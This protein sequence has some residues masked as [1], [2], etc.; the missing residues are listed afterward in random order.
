MNPSML[1][2]ISRSAA[3]WVAATS[4]LSSA[5]TLVIPAIIKTTFNSVNK[6][7]VRFIILYP[8]ALS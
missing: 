6:E 7:S 3:G 8:F 5:K 4:T 2:M 1:A